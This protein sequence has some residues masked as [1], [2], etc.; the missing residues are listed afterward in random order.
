MSSFSKH[1]EEWGEFIDIKRTNKRINIFKIKNKKVMISTVTDPYNSFEEKYATTRMIMEQLVKSEAFISVVTKSKLVLRDIDLFKK[2][3]HVEVAISMSIL[4]EQVK[5]KI[6]PYSSSIQERLDTLK[7][8]KQNGI[9]TIVFVAP[10]IPQFTDFKRIIEVTKD[11][12][13]EYWFDKLNLRSSFKTKMFKF[14]DGEYPIYKSIY[15]SIY[16][17]KDT[18]YF[19]ELS[20]EIEKYCTENN[21]SFKN[22]YAGT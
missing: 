11:Y 1:S 22:F 2:M 6:E 8:L 3:K 16:N 15:D 4:D 9:R 13:D 18:Q 21:I 10:I 20:D 14:I 7:T 17:R 19:D 12:T 5:K